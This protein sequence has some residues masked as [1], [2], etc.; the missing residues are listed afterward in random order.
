MRIGLAALL[1]AVMGVLG[2]GSSASADTSAPITKYNIN[3]TLTPE[4]STDV[5]IDMTMD[6]SQVRAGHL[7]LR[8]AH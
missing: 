1:L 3:A 6:F 4:G 7:T 8:R 5:T 2:L